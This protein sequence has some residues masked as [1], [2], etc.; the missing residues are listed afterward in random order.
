MQ[1]DDAPDDER[2]EGQRSELYKESYKIPGQIL[3]EQ[4]E[5]FRGVL[6]EYVKACVDTMLHEDTKK[7]Q[8]AAQ[9]ATTLYLELLGWA[10]LS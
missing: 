6:G 8:E 4:R 3:Q 2:R 9:R 1:I 7:R 5:K 10:Y